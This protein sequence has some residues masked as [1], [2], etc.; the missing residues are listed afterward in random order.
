MFN[1]S[2]RKDDIQDIDYYDNKGNE[3]TK[4]DDDSEVIV[5]NKGKKKT[6]R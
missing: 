5:L 6:H 1:P 3:E 4:N 2:T